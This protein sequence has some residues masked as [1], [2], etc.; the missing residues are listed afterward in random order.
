MLNVIK[1]VKTECNGNIYVV[2]PAQIVR[3]VK[4]KQYLA[5]HTIV[6]EHFVK[7]KNYMKKNKKNCYF[8]GDNVRNVG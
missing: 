5:R 2:F 3:D 4:G 6:G 1:D 8:T 7:R